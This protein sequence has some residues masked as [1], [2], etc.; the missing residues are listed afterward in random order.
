M[1]RA[2]ERFAAGVVGSLEMAQAQ[3]VLANANQNF[4]S[5]LSASNVAKAFLARALGEAE[6]GAKK[7]WGGSQEWQIA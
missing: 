2:E 6:A 1:R 5:S 3:E 4:I 7:L